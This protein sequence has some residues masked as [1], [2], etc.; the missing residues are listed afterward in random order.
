MGKVIPIANGVMEF[1][2]LATGFVL[3]ENG[4]ARAQASTYLRSMLNELSRQDQ[5]RIRHCET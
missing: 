2:E 4:I 5:R 3:P 1:D